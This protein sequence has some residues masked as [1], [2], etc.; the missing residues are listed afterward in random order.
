[1][2]ACDSLEA[3]YT[4]GVRPYPNVKRDPPRR[5]R[6]DA[7]AHY[8]FSDSQGQ[9]GTLLEK[10]DEDQRI[11]S[12]GSP[13]RK[14]WVQKV[15][16]D[17]CIGR[18]KMRVVDIPE[19]LQVSNHE[20]SPL[21]SFPNFHFN[22]FIFSIFHP[23][24][25]KSLGLRL[26]KELE[27]AVVRK[28]KKSADTADPTIPIEPTIDMQQWSGIV[29]KTMKCYDQGSED[30]NDAFPRQTQPF[31]QHQRRRGSLLVDDGNDNNGDTDTIISD[32]DVAVDPAYA[33]DFLYNS[34]QQSSPDCRARSMRD[35][36][37]R[38]ADQVINR[39][40]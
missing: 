14:R 16:D 13:A 5:G 28:G 26:S 12:M 33:D 31:D 7:M 24:S 40:I 35:V 25:T 30:S 20:S 38:I 10:P 27:K 8:P 36:K 6:P 2:E 32:G 15:Y 17:M 19:A 1:M 29:K 21:Y 9:V 11:F 39:L 3:Y 22:V 37:S 18:S 23:K 34:Q 4:S